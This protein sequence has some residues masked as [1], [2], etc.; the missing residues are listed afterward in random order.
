MNALIEMLNVARK[1]AD[2]SYTTTTTT[3]TIHRHQ[4]GREITTRYCFRRR[5]SVRLLYCMARTR[6]HAA[7]TCVDNIEW[8]WVKSAARSQPAVLNGPGRSA[9]AGALA[10]WYLPPSPSGNQS[11]SWTSAPPLL[12]LGLG[13]RVS[14]WVKLGSGYYFTKDRVSVL[15]LMCW[16]YG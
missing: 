7:W 1:N 15:G 10:P 5:E 4:F 16:G 12:G 3:T 6:L 8:C 2:L 11:S 9:I 13:V 14:V